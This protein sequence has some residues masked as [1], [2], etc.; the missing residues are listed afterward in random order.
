M[1]KHCC[2]IRAAA[3]QQHTQ[4]T[5]LQSPTN[6]HRCCIHNSSYLTSFSTIVRSSWFSIAHSLVV[7]SDNFVAASC[8]TWLASSA[9]PLA[10]SVLYIEA[11]GGSKS[12]AV[13]VPVLLV[14]E[15]LP[16]PAL[17]WS[18]PA[19][20]GLNDCLV[21]EGECT[22]LFGTSDVPCKVFSTSICVLLCLAGLKW[23]GTY[24]LPGGAA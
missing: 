22:G 7:S 21:R 20:V 8:A 14:A 12:A 11:A 19:A 2:A 4:A 17:F 13:T 9:G 6:C 10:N 5:L 1:A 16:L 3:Y 15:C 23:A 18:L 24:S